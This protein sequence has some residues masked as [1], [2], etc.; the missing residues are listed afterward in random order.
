MQ[1]SWKRKFFVISIGQIVSLIGSSAVQFALIWWIAS[2][3][4][5]AIMMGLSGLVAFLP[6]TILSPLAGI[7]ADRYHRKYICIFSDLFIGLSAAIFSIL[8]WIFEMPVW[9]ALLIL[10][11][12]SIGNAFHQPAF[13]AMIPQFVPAEDLVKIG[14]WNQLIASGSFLLGPAIGAALYAAFPL[15]VILLTDLFGA[16]IA[17]VM[18][19]VVH[20]A[21][22]MQKASRESKN[23]LK[24]LKEG[25]EV[26]RADKALT[27]LIAIETLCMIFYMPL[28]SFYPLMTSDYFQAS[29]WHG[30][31]IEVLYAAGMMI[32]AF[33]FGSVIKVKRHLFL[34]Y[35]GLLGIGFTSTIG[36]ILPPEMWAWFIFALVCGV[37]GAFGNVH[38][39]PL[40]AYMQTTIPAEKMGRAFSLI[41]LVASLSMP[42][43][44]L[45]GSPIA[46]RIG[47]NVWFFISGI[48][49]TII[50]AIGLLLHHKIAKPAEPVNDKMNGA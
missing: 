38:S 27:L 49:T 5:S 35:L 8:L 41:A 42:L 12:R 18:L 43:G 21:A 16:V 1:Q 20:I 7:V 11:F 26:F 24:E 17:S 3:T 22:P 39:I 28:S 40:V 23:T 50:T 14:G 19:A 37:M 48:G 9:T 15:P 29:A 36:G 2:E 25:I 31:A 4:G 34:S 13:Q 33:L 32:A 47:V 6:A 45:I 30:S 10:F 44:L 46:E